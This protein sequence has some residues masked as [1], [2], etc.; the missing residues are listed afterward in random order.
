MYCYITCNQLLPGLTV[1]GM[2]QLMQDNNHNNR[3]GNN[4]NNNHLCS[5][6]FEVLFHF[7][8]TKHFGSQFSLFRMSCN[9]S[10]TLF[11]LNVS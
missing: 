4:N 5:N 1:A 9:E 7:L 8:A 2:S 3:Y 10:V 6:I 11:A